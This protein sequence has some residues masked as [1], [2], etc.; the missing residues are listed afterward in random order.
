MKI[1]KREEKRRFE[2]L[3][4]KPQLLLRGPFKTGQEIVKGIPIPAT[5]S[6]AS[7]KIKKKVQKRSK[8]KSQLLLVVLFFL[9]KFKEIF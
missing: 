6:Q 8:K 1:K 9:K 5:V 7:K 2:R 4:P 3:T